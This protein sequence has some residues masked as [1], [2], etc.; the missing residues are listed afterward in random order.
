MNDLSPEAREVANQFGIHTT[1]P[2]F[3]GFA[4]HVN[5]TIQDCLIE[6]CDTFPACSYL[7]DYHPWYFA[8]ELYEPYVNLS[9]PAHADVCGFEDAGPL[10]AEIGGIGVRYNDFFDRL[11]EEITD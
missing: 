5:R 3:S 4:R 1:S 6:Y 11:R 8:L 7:D 2:W 9:V 10:N